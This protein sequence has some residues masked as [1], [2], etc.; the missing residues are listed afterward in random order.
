MDSAGELLRWVLIISCVG[1]GMMAGL[2]VSFST[3]MMKALGSLDRSEGMRAMQAINRLI[4][5]PSFLLIFIGTAA[6]STT[7]AFLSYDCVGPWRYICLSAAIY[8][9]G[10][11]L[12]TIAF[13]IPLNNQLDNADSS[14]DE[15]HALWDRYL[16]QWTHWNHLRSFATLVSTVLL[17]FALSEI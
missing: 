13:N 3:F 2:F 7:S 8:T 5:R 12:S 11:L 17:A 1:S 16:V 9:V 14:I 15:G 6:F 10:C 4:V